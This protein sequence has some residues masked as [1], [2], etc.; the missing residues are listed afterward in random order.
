MAAEIS[1]LIPGLKTYFADLMTGTDVKI[2]FPDE[3]VDNTEQRSYPAATLSMF[4]A[5]IGVGRRPGGPPDYTTD[6]PTEN[7]TKCLQV[8]RPAPID[9]GLQLDI[10]AEKREHDWALTTQMLALFAMQFPR[11]EIAELGPIYLYPSVFQVLDD[12]DDGIFRKAYRFT[13]PLWFENSETAQEAIRVLSIE[14]SA[15]NEPLT[16]AAPA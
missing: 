15:N 1:K 13:V 11:V 12:L 2:A 9:I 16:I 14:M 10:Y 5:R 3:R 6:H 8:N 4:D 7:A